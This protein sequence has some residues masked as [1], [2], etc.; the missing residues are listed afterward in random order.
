M[1][2]DAA[3]KRFQILI[4]FFCLFSLSCILHC[5]KGNHNDDTNAPS[6]SWHRHRYDFEVDFHGIPNDESAATLEH[7][8]K[9]FSDILKYNASN[10]AL[11][12]PDEIFHFY[13]GIYGSNILN[14]DLFINGTLRFHRPKVTK[15]NHWDR[16]EP[17]ILIEDSVNITI[18]SPEPAYYNEQII[19]AQDTIHDNQIDY[20]YGSRKRGILDGH[21]SDYWGVPF[22]GYVQLIEFRPDLLVMNRTSNVLIEYLILRDSGLYTMYLLD[23][24]N[25]KVRYTSIV[26]RRTNDDGHSLLDLSAFNT[27]GIDVSGNNVYMH[28]VDIWNQDDCIAVKDSFLAESTNM[29]FER[30]TASG[31]GLVVGS[32]GGTTVRNITFRDS[33][34]YKTYKGIYM[35]FRHDEYRDTPG[36]VENIL[37]ENITLYEPEQW[38]IWI[39]PAQQSINANPCHANPC[40][41][42]WP[43]L[44]FAT[45]DGIEQSQ[46]RNITLRDIKIYHPLG[47]PGVIL[48]DDSNPIQDIVFDN[49]I[50]TNYVPDSIKNIDRRRLFFGLNEPIQDPYMHPIKVWIYMAGFFIILGG[51]CIVV[52]LSLIRL[53]GLPMGGWKKRSTQSS[54]SDKDDDEFPK[55]GNT[56]SQPKT[57]VLM[58]FT[59]FVA[60]FVQRII[61]TS[62]ETYDE[63]AYFTCQGVVN[64]IAMG[65][66]WPVPSCF[67]DFT[68]SN[69]N[70]GS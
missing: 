65:S 53:I 22:I 60:S 6:S 10:N 15:V 29:L 52:F 58:I 12:I 38:G 49:V 39:G 44:P 41:L 40:S 55:L 3:T 9:T 21:G 34:L 62:E 16:P 56:L 46:Y 50:V 19:Q 64:G 63:H 4:Q 43:T 8:T 36:L 61:S 26:A 37:F 27:D 51:L 5:V 68:N 32:I 1:Y 35:K 30:I 70:K 14:F 2:V 13:P 48:A 18:T 47:S 57:M 25:L 45:C 33:F 42:C 11:L 54:Q 28:D 59:V 24:D 69:I 23:V 67:E 31:L 17:C 66:T 7:N 20:D